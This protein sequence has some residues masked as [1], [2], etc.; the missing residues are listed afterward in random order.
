MCFIRA[1]DSL[2]LK[3]KID[4]RGISGIEEHQR[5]QDRQKQNHLAP[6]FAQIQHRGE[7]VPVVLGHSDGGCNRDDTR[8]EEREDIV[9]LNPAGTRDDAPE[10]R[11]RV[12]K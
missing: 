10:N 6:E 4:E 9:V 12:R 3:L 2:R 8:K 11:D 7:P 5:E 1:L